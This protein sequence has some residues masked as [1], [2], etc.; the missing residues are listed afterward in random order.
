MNINVPKDED[1]PPQ[2]SWSEDRVSG[3]NRKDKTGFLRNPQPSGFEFAYLS[4]HFREEIKK[5]LFNNYTIH[6]WKYL[7]ST[8]LDLLM[9]DLSYFVFC[10]K[11]QL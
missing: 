8:L 1:R 2:H 5:L 4:A 6:K 11:K 3:L 9:E 10:G 7:I